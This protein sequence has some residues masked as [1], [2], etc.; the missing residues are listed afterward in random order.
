M[1]LFKKLQAALPKSKGVKISLIAF[2]IVGVIGAV[3]V[4]LL[5][6]NLVMGM[7]IINLPGAPIDKPTK[8]EA[9]VDET[10]EPEFVDVPV[11]N[12]KLPDPWDGKSRVNLLLMGLDYR[13]WQAGDIPRTDTMILFTLD[14]IHNTAGMIS[15]PRDLWV[16]IPGFDYDKINTAYFLG[17][18]WKMPGGGPEMAK[19]TVEELLG[20]PIQYYAQVDFTAFESFIDNIDGVKV[21]VTEEVRIDPI[22]EGEE[23]KPIYLQPGTH[24]LPGNLAL[25][26][27]RSRSTEGGDFDRANRQQQ[28]VLGIRDRIV[29][30]NMMPKLIANAE[31]L[32][33][34]LSS[35]IKTNL[36]LDQAIKLGLKALEVPKDQI[37]HVV[38]T[39]Q[40]VN[41]A[42]SPDGLDI[43]V[44]ITDKI[45]LLRDEIFLSGIAVG[46]AATGSDVLELAKLENATIAIQNGS[47]VEGLAEETAEYLRSMGLQVVEAVNTDYIFYSQVNL[48]GSKPYTLKYLVELMNITP[49]SRITVQY[50]S[51]SQVDIVL[52]L[53]QDW[54]TENPM[55]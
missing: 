41:F 25:A 8:V 5:V 12:L 22:G 7:T 37:K 14:P 13:D 26:Y 42:K 30:F 31:K 21:K 53:G 15:I 11:E 54:G 28:V 20:V 16:P 9:V 35:G 34:D 36:G 49:S 32:Y 52:F 24:V 44:P 40:Y 55:P 51:N 18:A 10:Q 2:I 29:K 17:E 27:A 23:G 45:R 50:D 3:L 46:P 47:G 39:G 48:F 19:R 43:L 4:G 1:S 38:I 6:R 33:G